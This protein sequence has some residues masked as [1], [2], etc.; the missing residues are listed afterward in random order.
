MIF[1]MTGFTLFHVV[2][3]LTGI[4]SGLVV[5]AGLVSSRRMDGWTLTFLVTTVATSATGFGFPFTVLLPSHIVG[6]ISL[7]VLAIAIYARYGRKLAGAARW[8]Y[9]TGVVLAL[10]LN[11]FVLVVQLFR[12]VDVLAALAPTQTE[13][14]FKIVQ[15]VFL[16]VFL[17]LG[18]AAVKR[19]RPAAGTHEQ[20]VAA[21]A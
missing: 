3:S 17:G 14:P 10:Y 12:R 13:A 4:A 19:F 11:V 1:G 5:T 21:A 7:V 8:I 20:R 16:A 18:V 15:I 2:V 6:I 9:V